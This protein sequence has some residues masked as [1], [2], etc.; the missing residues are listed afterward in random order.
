M[1]YIQNIVD[2]MRRRTEMAQP[3]RGR[4]DRAQRAA[5]RTFV[6]LNGWRTS[7]RFLFEDIRPRQEAGL[8]R[9]FLGR[10]TGAGQDH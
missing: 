1:T 10:A 5:W 7:K 2:A 8:R 3:D 6:S 4:V 9:R